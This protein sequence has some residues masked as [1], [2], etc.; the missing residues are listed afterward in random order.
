[1][2]DSYYQ[3]L[4][5]EESRDI[6]TFTEGINL[7]RFK[8]LPFGLSCSASVFIQQLNT[9]LAPLLKSPWI[10]TY[11]DD[12][13]SS[14]PTYEVLTQRLDIV[15]Q[16]MTEKGIKLNLSK[17][18]IGH[19]EIKFLGHVVSQK[20]YGPDPSNIEAINNMKALQNIKEVRKFLGMC[21][22]YRQ[23][24]PRY[25]SIAALLTELT[26]KDQPFVWTS[27]CPEAFE[28][29]KMTM[30]K[31][32]ILVKVNHRKRYTGDGR[33]PESYGCGTDAI[34]R[35]RTSPGDSLIL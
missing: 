1:M 34:Q 31:A 7:Y 33:K 18:H 22:F 30:T 14:T 19:K 24:V 10:K 9:A 4:L 29:L 15:F 28:A 3:V 20:G 25:A 6:T 21:S 16:H 13:I 5:D 26:K 17:C 32:P 27:E 2:K 12:V 8:R 35:R 11:L 23:H